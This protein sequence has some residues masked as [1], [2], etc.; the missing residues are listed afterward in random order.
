MRMLPE[1]VNLSQASQIT[2]I[3]QVTLKRH[4]EKG[5]LL[6]DQEEI[7]RNYRISLMDLEQYA[8]DIYMNRDKF[9]GIAMYNPFD[10]FANL[11]DIVLRKH[12]RK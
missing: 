11:R 5:Y 8:F 2:G 12:T 1:F 3:N 6:A 10:H 4:I 7:G 9:H